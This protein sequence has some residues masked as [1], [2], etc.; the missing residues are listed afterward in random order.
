MQSGDAA[1]ESSK[2]AVLTGPRHGI[3]EGLGRQ[4]VEGRRVGELHTAPG[5]PGLRLAN[6]ILSSAALVAG[7]GR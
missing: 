7:F 3:S 1:L 5:G 6:I 4:E 2:C